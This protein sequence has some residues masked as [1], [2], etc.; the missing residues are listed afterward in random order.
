[1]FRPP[2]RVPTSARLMAIAAA[3]VVVACGGG[4]SGRD[5]PLPERTLAVSSAA[6]ED[7][8]SIP[9][10]FTCEG[11]DRS[12]PLAW[13]SGPPGTAA[14]AVVV[15]DPDAPG[16]IFVH[17]TVWNL[18]PSDTSLPAGASSSGTLPPAVREGRNDFGRNGWA[19]PCPPKGDEPHRYR[20]RV[21]ALRE[22]LDV[23]SGAEPG[24]VLGALEGKVLAW[25]E[26]IGL[27]G[28]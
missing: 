2:G 24:R 11:A 9:V 21:Y 14:Y 4:G 16:G 7:G 1:M 19:G 23:P 10:E 3:V 6:F 12:P 26:L 15:D 27:F 13:E 28:R 20:F 5:L 18:P 17:W 8:S 25:G 22:P